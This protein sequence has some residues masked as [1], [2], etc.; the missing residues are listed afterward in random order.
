M[1]RGS[2]AQFCDDRLVAVLAVRGGGLPS[3]FHEAE[4]WIPDIH[5]VLTN[6]DPGRPSGRPLKGRT[7]SEKAWAVVTGKS[8]AD[9]QWASLVGGVCT[10]DLV[11]TDN[12]EERAH[13]IA[14]A[15]ELLKACKTALESL[16]H[17]ANSGAGAYQCRAAIAKAEGKP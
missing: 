10:L 2:A 12:V 8:L 16:E 17:F 4:L 14:A 13:L 7:M 6:V 15:P 9:L 1:R 11:H 5:R 3:G